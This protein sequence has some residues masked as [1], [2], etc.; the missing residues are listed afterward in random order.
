MS[1]I[2]DVGLIGLG[3]M[4]QNLALNIADHG[5][6][7]AVFNR[8]TSV[9]K[10]FVGANPRTPGRLTACETL[11]A[12]TTSLKRPRRA[13]LMLPAGGPTDAVIDQLLA[14]L[15][16]G[17][18]IVDGS[19]AH[20]ED[21]AKREARCAAR[22]VHYVGSGVSGGEEGARFGPS[23][24]PGGSR[25]AYTLIEPIWRDIAAKVDA[26]TG[27]PIEGA[28]P[29]KPA[30][31][32]GAEPCTAY[33]GPGGAGHF[34]KMIHNGIEYVDMQLIAESYALLRGVGCLSVDECAAVFAE[35]NA[36]ELDSFLIEITAG[37][38]RQRD[39]R[40]SKPFVE[41][42]LDAAGQKGTGKW[43]AQVAL[44]LGVSAPAIAEAVFARAISA[45][46]EERVRASSVLAGPAKR[47]AAPADIVDM[48]RDALYCGKISAYA[49][50]FALLAA[51][52]KKYEW[53]LKF[54]EI[55]RIWRGGCIIRARFLQ[56]ITDAFTRDAALAN[57][58]LD[59]HFASEIA[60]RQGAW[61]EVAALAALRGVPAPAL[62]TSL[63]Y[64]DGYRSA[65][66]SANLI[67]AQR[68]FFGA[69]TY[70][71]TDEPRGRFFHLEWSSPGRAERPA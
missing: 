62:A 43:S 50:G 37:V 44:E 33:I 16:K 42:V 26:R 55:A 17:D 51:A 59:A 69:H 58:M 32:D 8:T 64:Y 23:L 61:R 28:A 15:E 22:S 49:Q 24:M 53:G 67:Q 21:T 34:V 45:I 35:W 57:L 56:H 63:A 1:A 2:A 7:T 71:R 65:T 10:E 70:E 11:E 52:S 60:R 18:L 5:H 9:T 31:A 13:I 29:G 30:R 6:A 19:N 46:K 41:V 47:D 36:G 14:L 27:K 3:V 39:P 68:D 48:V 12:F 40:T 38:L 20:W 54:G 4:G 25:E 66:L